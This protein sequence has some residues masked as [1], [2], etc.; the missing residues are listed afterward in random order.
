VKDTTERQLKHALVMI[1][2]ALHPVDFDESRFHGAHSAREAVE[3]WKA[4]LDNDAALSKLRGIL[5]DTGDRT[6]R[7]FDRPYFDGNGPRSALAG[8]VLLDRVR[9]GLSTMSGVNQGGITEA[10]ARPIMED[11]VQD[12]AMALLGEKVTFKGQGPF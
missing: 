1:G 12:V 5:L 4:L 6:I 3:A 7:R 11:I 8:Q 9:Y 10:E 2:N